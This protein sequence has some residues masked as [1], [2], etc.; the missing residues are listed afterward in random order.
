MVAVAK[1]G[2]LGK[3]DQPNPPWSPGNKQ[4]QVSN[5]L[6]EQMSPYGSVYFPASLSCSPSDVTQWTQSLIFSV[7]IWLFAQ[8]TWD[9][10]ISLCSHPNVVVLNI[11]CIQKRIR[12]DIVILILCDILSLSLKTSHTIDKLLSARVVFQ[13]PEQFASWVSWISL[14]VLKCV[15]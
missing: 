2:V 5:N 1:R 11:P 13:H 14:I 8:N 6:T 7:W 3:G 15:L 12:R 9:L 10:F 4:L